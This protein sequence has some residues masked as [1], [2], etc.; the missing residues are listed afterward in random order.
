MGLEDQSIEFRLQVPGDD[1][2]YVGNPEDIPTDLQ[3]PPLKDDRL[4]ILNLLVIP[5]TFLVE[6]CMSF[7]IML[8]PHKLMAEFDA[9][10]KED[11]KLHDG[12]FHEVL[13]S[14]QEAIVL[15]P[16]VALSIRLRPGI[17]EYIRVN[18]NALVVEE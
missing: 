13:K 6:L 16:W 1:D 5:S 4:D 9:I 18:V 8:K 3:N 11:T 12:A 7:M 15:P 17:W 2:G 14:T 10:T